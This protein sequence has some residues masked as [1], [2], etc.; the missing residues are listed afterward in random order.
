MRIKSSAFVWALWLLV[1]EV[2]ILALTMGSLRASAQESS[3]GK[4]T[5]TTYCASCHTIGGGDLVGPDLAGVTTR[6]D[7]AWLTRWITEPDKML[8]EG[9]TIATEMLTQYNNVP[10]PNLKLSDTDVAALVT[11]LENVDSGAEPMPVATPRSLPTGDVARGQAL[12]LGTTRFEKGGPA[13]M[14][15]HSVSGIGALGG[16][17]LGVDLT[18]IHQRYGGDAGLS[19]FLGNPATTTMNA[20][21]SNQP[22]SEQEKADLVAFLGST[23][24]STRSGTT[25]WILAALSAL[26]AAATIL[27]AHLWWRNRLASVR[28]PMVAQAATKR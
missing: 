26:A 5:Y 17:A 24:V 13:C 28:K 16:G 21:W 10:M 19:A 1:I 3:P 4:T 15:C 22:M 7:K 8:A 18:D 25:L 2:V 20:V 23:T 9:D 6:R 14:V 12:F 27:A 11:Y